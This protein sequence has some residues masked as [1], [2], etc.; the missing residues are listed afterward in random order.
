M[1]RGKKNPSYVRTAGQVKK[2]PQYSEISQ[3]RL[4]GHRELARNL[5]SGVDSLTMPP[6]PNEKTPYSGRG[7]L[8]KVLMTGDDR[9]V[10]KPPPGTIPG[11]SKGNAVGKMMGIAR[12]GPRGAY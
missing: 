8:S 7:G 3:S 4:R 1:A 2:K 12:K 9:G 11:G 5:D 6:S 10:K